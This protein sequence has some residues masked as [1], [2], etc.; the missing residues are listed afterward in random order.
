[1]I[2]LNPLLACSILLCFTTIIAGCESGSEEESSNQ[3]AGKLNP[4]GV[5]E[6]S[7][8]QAKIDDENHSDIG[9]GV[10]FAAVR[11]VE[12]KEHSK[13]LP[14]ALTRESSVNSS[15][16]FPRYM[17]LK[18]QTYDPIDLSESACTVSGT[19]IYTFSGDSDIFSE[20]SVANILWEYDECI[21][22]VQLGTYT[23]DGYI[24]FEQGEDYHFTTYEIY[25]TYDLEDD[26]L[27]FQSY[28][29]NHTFRCS[30]PIYDYELSD[31]YY[32]HLFSVGGINYQVSELEFYSTGNSYSFT[33]KVY[34]EVY[35]Y[36]TID[37][38]DLVYCD[39]GS[40]MT[41]TVSVFDGS[42][43]GEMSIYYSSCEGPVSI[44]Y[45]GTTIEIAQ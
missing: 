3:G 10:H 6:G 13:F 21:A 44:T 30:G 28:Y 24:Y 36:V 4:S 45:N 12:S 37:A 27:L 23:Y 29:T 43:T 40:F 7:I 42:G 8:S 19:L 35:G 25:L 34:H 17:N 9:E 41:G 2:Q 33:A 16:A 11:S 1:M 38:K 14:R 22:T 31:C 15:M 39:N 18:R 20:G 26:F 32:S 5:Y